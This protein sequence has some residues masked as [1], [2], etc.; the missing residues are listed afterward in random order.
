MPNSKEEIG[1]ADHDLE[2]EICT[3]KENVSIDRKN[4]KTHL[5]NSRLQ[6]RDSED[7]SEGWELCG[8]LGVYQAQKSN[9]GFENRK[10]NNMKDTYL[11]ITYLETSES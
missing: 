3:V 5:E 10:K 8:K 2:S 6:N 1:P 4:G 7:P 11:M 9:G